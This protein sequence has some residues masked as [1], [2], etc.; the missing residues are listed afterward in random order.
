M[1]VVRDEPSNG[2]SGI[3]AY[4]GLDP[5]IPLKAQHERY[6]VLRAQGATI[7]RACREI[8]SKEDN[9]RRFWEP[10]ALKAD[11]T[12]TTH[13]GSHFREDGVGGAI[14]RRIQW[15]REAMAAES[16]YTP[17]ML[18]HMEIECI[19][20]AQA[21]GDYATALKYIDK[22]RC[23]VVEKSVQRVTDALPVSSE[24]VTGLLRGGEGD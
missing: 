8:G 19:Q 7:G 3:S 16:A 11:G 24:D 1:G 15:L 9:V 14:Q 12:M 5:S 2:P 6:A 23:E 21:K 10:A 4:R 22:L 13:L 17:G 18:L 20:K